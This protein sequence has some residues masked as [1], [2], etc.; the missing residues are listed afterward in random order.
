MLQDTAAKS[1]SLSQDTEQQVLRPDAGTAQGGRLAPRALQNG[2]RVG[3]QALDRDP[4]A[5]HPLLPGDQAA[6]LLPLQPLRAQDVRAQSVALGHDA[7]QQMLGPDAA[8]PQLSG[9][10]ACALDGVLRPLCKLLV[11]S[12]RSTLPMPLSAASAAET[13]ES[14]RRVEYRQ[15]PSKI[16]AFS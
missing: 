16:I 13:D 4:G 11:A 9:G 6:Q 10:R 5:A 3:R 15:K 2:A 1:L 8:V 7:E 12:D 14:G